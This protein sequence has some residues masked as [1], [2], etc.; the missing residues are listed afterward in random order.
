MTDVKMPDV[1]YVDLL[2]HSLTENEKNSNIKFYPLRPSSAGKCSYALYNDLKEYN[3]DVK[4][5]EKKNKEP[6]VIRLLSLGHSIEFSMI[7]NFK[8]MIK[9]F[10]Y[11]IKYKQQVVSVFTLDDGTVVEG[12]IDFC[13]ENGDYKCV[14]DAKSMKDAF[15]GFRKTRFDEQLEKYS[16]M[17]SLT[18]LSNLCFYAEDVNALVTELKDDFKVDN[19]VQLNLYAC[20]DFFKERGYDHASLLYYNKNDSRMFEIR[21]KP[22]DKLRDKIKDKYQKVYDAKDPAKVV[23]DFKLGS[24]RCAFCDYNSLCYANANSLQEWFNT[25]HNKKKFPTNINKIKEKDKV[26]ELF[27]KYYELI[28]CN[29]EQKEVESEIC[30]ILKEQK[31]NKIKVD[32]EYTFE[33]KYLKSPKPHWALRRSK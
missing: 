21:F 5:I 31:I 14:C 11:K 16:K 9:E 33:V 26:K 13:L 10:D 6:N 19:I 15:S 8:S 1:G 20:T 12:S 32:N 30:E 23:R 22:S 28:K 24:I 2:D 18:K 7:N 4:I 27:N 25:L 17:K 29:K 3:S